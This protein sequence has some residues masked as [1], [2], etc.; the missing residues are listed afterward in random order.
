MIQLVL[1]SV[2]CVGKVYPIFLFHY[3]FIWCNYHYM[4]S[5]GVFSKWFSS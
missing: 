3:E 5:I 4:K 1:M 2:V